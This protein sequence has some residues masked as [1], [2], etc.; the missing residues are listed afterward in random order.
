MSGFDLLSSLFNLDDVK[1]LDFTKKED[2]DKLKNVVATLKKG[3]NPLFN[4]IASI[5]GQ[6][7]FDDKLLDKLIEHATQVYNDAHKNDIV[8]KPSTKVSDKMQCQI[9]KLTEEYIN[10]M[11]LKGEFTEA[12]L[13][14]IYNSLFEFACWIYSK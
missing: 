11:L 9:G 3:D 10:T 2:L 7:T 6:E 5:F 4:M 8:E 14:A 1:E 12:Q 13:R